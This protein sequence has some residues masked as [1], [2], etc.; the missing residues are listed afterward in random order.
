MAF[1]VNLDELFEDVVVHDYTRTRK[2][3]FMWYNSKTGVI[4][5]FGD[6]ASIKNKYT[7]QVLLECIRGRPIARVME[8]KGPPDFGL[9]KALDQITDY[10]RERALEEIDTIREVVR[11]PARMAYQKLNAVPVTTKPYPKSKPKPK[12]DSELKPKED[13]EKDSEEE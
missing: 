3:C 11:E 2:V 7:R 10:N 12:E 9:E 4:Y 5:G 13:S 8:I 1:Q 6:E